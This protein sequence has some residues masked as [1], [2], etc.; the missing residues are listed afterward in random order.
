MRATGLTIV[1]VLMLSAC[2]NGQQ[3]ARATALATPG[4]ASADP[5]PSAG[6]LQDDP[7]SDPMLLMPSGTVN[8]SELPDPRSA[9]AQLVAQYC[10]QCH[11]VPSPAGHSAAEWAPIVRNMLLHMERAASMQGMMGGRGMMG[12][13]GM[14]G[15]GGMMMAPVEV[16]SPEQG[17][18]ILGYLQAHA[19][20][21]IPEGQA[22]QGR[23]QTLFDQTCSRC[24]ALPDPK[25]HT[26]AEWPAVVQ[27]MRAH[28]QQSH[29]AGITNDQANQID[30]Y[31]Q[32]AAGPSR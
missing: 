1:A 18:T 19:M 5:G 12:R 2:R 26:A 8:P 17:R 4:A 13:G 20:R 3:Q 32:K 23:G 6:A 7:A 31:L 24:H 28:M 25:Q 14:M 11:G 9:G 29:V 15:G 16:P 21:A 22:P 10:S 27:R 30:T